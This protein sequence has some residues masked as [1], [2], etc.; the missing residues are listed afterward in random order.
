MG[1]RDTIDRWVTLFNAGDARGIAELYADD[2][3]NHQ[4]ALSP[5]VGRAAIEE[6]HRGVFAGQ[7]VCTPINVVSEGNWVALEWVD[8]EGFRGCGF[9]Q[10]TD[11][12]IVHQRGYWDS[13]QL[14]A[15]HPEMH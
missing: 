8:P 7:P 6:F 11:G 3:V 12:L 10:V 1:A 15:V 14:R 13:A 4:V 5:V 9:F 2:A